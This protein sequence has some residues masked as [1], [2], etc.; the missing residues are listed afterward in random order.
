MEV[1]DAW[2]FLIEYGIASEE[3][4]RVVT[5]INGYNLETLENVLYSETG[6]RTFEQYK[7]AM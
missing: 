2:D 3:T 4:L 6:Y 7:E 1:G 5:N